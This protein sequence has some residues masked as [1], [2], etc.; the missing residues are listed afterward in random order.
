MWRTKSTEAVGAVVVVVGA[1]VVVVGA[2][3]VVAGTVVVVAGTVVVVVGD[4]QSSTPLSL[5][6]IRAGDGFEIV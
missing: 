2:V 6:E 4:I 5:I 1:V 3:V